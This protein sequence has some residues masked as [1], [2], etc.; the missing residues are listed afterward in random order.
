MTTRIAIK[1]TAIFLLLFTAA[2][3]QNMS[4]K[5]KEFWVGYGHHHFFETG[6]NNQTMVLYLSAEQTAHVTVSING[7]SYTQTYT[8]PANSV[9]QTAALPKSGVND[10]RLY[11]GAPGFTGTLSEGTSN[12]GIH[13]VSDVPIVAYAH[14]YGSAS[15]GATMLMPVETYGYS[16]VSV[17]SQQRYGTNN[18]FSWIYII[19]KENNTVVEIVPS[20]NTRGG[21]PANSAYTVTLNKGQVYQVLGALISASEGYDLS[22]TKVRSIANSAGNCYPIAVFAGS[23]RTYITCSGTGGSGGDNIIQ[24]IFPFQAWGKRYLTAPTSN[25][26]SP[27]QLMTNLYRVAVKDPRTV[28]KVNG[29][30]LTNLIKNSYY[31]YQSNTADYIEADQPILVAQYMASNGSCPNTSGDGDPEM[32]YISPIE[33]AIKKVGFYRNNQEDINQNYLTLIIPSEGLS[34]LLIDGSP[35]ISYSYDHPNLPGYT[36]VIKRWPAAQAQCIVQSDSAFTAITYGLGYVES[37]GYN[38]G[39][40][41]NNLSVIGSVHNSL[42]V[43]NHSNLF[44]CPNTPAEI[45]MLV[46]YR[47]TS[48]FWNLSQVTG[49]RPNTDL[50]VSN[51]VPDETVVVNGSTYYRYS[52]PNTYYFADTGTYQIPVRNTHPSIDNCNNSETVLFSVVVKPN[53]KADFSISYTGCQLDTAHLNGIVTTSNAYTIGSWQWTFPDGSTSNIRNPDKVFNTPGDRDVKLHVVS[54]EGC[55]GDTIK[56]ISIFAKPDVRIGALPASV[57]EGGTISFSDTSS[58]GGPAPIGSWYWDFGNGTT[59]SPTTNAPQTITFPSSGIYTVKHL[60][61]VSSLCVS[62]TVQRI[63]HVYA[64]PH[65]GFTY[66]AGCL[67]S[68]GIVTFNSTSTVP[69]GQ[70]LSY[71]WNFGDPSATSSNP[72]F[73][74]DANPSHNYSTGTYTVLYKVTTEQGCMHDTTVNASFNLR[75]M[76]SYPTLPAVCASVKG[77]VSVAAAFVTNGVTGTG[78][79]RGPS[80]D[81]AGHFSPSAAGPGTYTIWYVFRSAGGCTDSVSSTIRVYPKPLASFTSA[82][83]ICLN[84][85]VTLSDHSTISDGSVVRWNWD[86]GDGSTNSFTNGNPFDKTFG[87]F[88]NY[89]V[90]LVSVS[91]NG[92]TSDTISHTI[93]VHPLPTAGFSL[94]GVICMPGGQASFSSTATVVDNATLNYNWDFGDGSAAATTA[95]PTHIY[96]TSGSYSVHLTVTTADGCSRDSV[97]ILNSFSNQPI[98]RFQVSPDTLCQGTNNVFTDE[99]TA[100]GGTLQSWTWSF[101]DGSPASNAQNPVKKYAQPGKFGVSLIVKNA[102]GCTSAAY[103]DTVIV[104]LQPVIDAGLSFVV[105]QGTIV[106]FHP[107]ANDSTQ[108][109]F[110]WQPAGDFTN[111]N[112]LSPALL[113]IHNET[114]TLT[115]TGAGNCTASDQ[116]TVKILKPVNVM[117]SFSP[118]GDGIND[119]W[120]IPNLADYPGCTVEVFNR[121]GQLVYQSVGYGTPWNGTFKGSS[122][123]VATYYYVIT[124]KNG[125]APVTGSVTIIK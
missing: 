90:R 2:R 65:L 71:S 57:C 59:S 69:D 12:R 1:L 43:T 62:D 16:Y 53:P 60:A 37:Y 81:D 91:E 67:P 61:R 76:L 73:S 121:Y 32:M 84:Q 22:G 5:G 47:P 38:A 123:P 102:A 98:A 34:S 120:N 11:S 83:S 52:L 111:P 14:I 44:T 66:P 82:A 58:Y 104:Y 51:P 122:L 42:D 113:A 50:T 45:S 55:V 93:A 117:N 78:L 105:T 63:I 26:S 72:N 86:F 36:V 17:N 21:H 107:A 77:S 49:L 75:P 7:T 46:A 99:S 28:V 54:T 41:I 74:T 124:L 24:Q 89:N 116:L 20:V 27:A 39:T 31:D 18:C 114:Y 35:S 112:V 109:R 94:P 30:P 48:M 68:N 4:N 103:R 9:I 108:L 23:S 80:T 92:C 33:Q 70:T 85:A 110:Q 13:I 8:V 97:R 79:Y 118:N 56:T 40:M 10:C 115:A 6:A 125:F 3:A 101:G 106:R 100:P 25:S 15:S 19:A 96:S 64:Q 87:T 88:G 29:T 95:A 119:T